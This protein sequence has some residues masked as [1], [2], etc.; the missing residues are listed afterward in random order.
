MHFSVIF[1]GYSIVR[2]V[3]GKYPAELL[4]AWDQF[5]LNN[6]TENNRPDYFTA[7]QHYVLLC[8]ENGGVSL[9]NFKLTSL[10]EAKSILQQ[11]IFTLALLEKA[12]KF[13][14]RDLHVSNILVRGT[15]VDYLEYI[16]DGDR[17]TVPSAGLL[18]C[19]VDFTLSRLQIDDQVIYAD[20]SSHSHIFSGSGEMQFYVYPLMRKIIGSWETFNPRT[21]VL[22]IAYLAD[23][24]AHAKYR[25]RKLPQAKKA[26]LFAF[27][28]RTKS[29]GA[30]SAFVASSSFHSHTKREIVE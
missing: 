8:M 25:N 14:H 12:L 26:R 3:K 24:L 23:F 9:E 16:I 30:C 28:R 19:M 27:K 1:L 20:L 5:A 6:R 4:K 18:C 11:M 22:W 7:D 21:N 10:E 2:C 15:K 17:L 29:W 13:E